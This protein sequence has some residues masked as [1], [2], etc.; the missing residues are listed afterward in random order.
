MEPSGLVC[1]MTA[2]DVR[3][4]FTLELR[5]Q[6][7][8][9]R[10]TIRWLESEVDLKRGNLAGGAFLGLLHTFQEQIV[11]HFRFEEANG[12]EGGFGSSDPELHA[13]ASGLIRQHRELEQ[14][15]ALA[16]QGLDLAQDPYLALDSLLAL[17]AFFRE[18]RKH[19]AIEDAI[20]QRLR[21]ETVE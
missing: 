17:R 16:V 8:A 19:D 15:L 12:I 21:H 1:I 6:H 3:F 7:A 13:L 11:A 5:E 4:P 20:L 9:L 18:M 14:R 10:S 2:L